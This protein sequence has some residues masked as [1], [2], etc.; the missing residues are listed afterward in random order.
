MSAPV[1]EDGNIITANGNAFN[2]FA[3][4]M[5]HKVGYECSERILSGYLDDWTEEDYLHHLSRE[6]LLEFQREFQEFL[7]K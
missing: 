7:N 3:V 2:D 5:A 1:V 6:D 4:H